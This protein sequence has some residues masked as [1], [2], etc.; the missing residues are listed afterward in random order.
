MTSCFQLCDGF[1]FLRTE[2]NLLTQFTGICFCFFYLGA[3]FRLHWNR[4]THAKKSGFCDIENSQYVSMLQCGFLPGTLLL[5]FFVQEAPTHNLDFSLNVT[6]S[7]KPFL[8]SHSPTL[9]WFS[10]TLCL[11]DQ[12]YYHCHIIGIHNTIA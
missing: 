7:R 5:F 6:S 8:K 11:Q 9:S 3:K 1:H 10:S 12:A 4:M 2:S